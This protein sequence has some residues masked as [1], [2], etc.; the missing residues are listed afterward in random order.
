MRSIRSLL[1][2]PPEQ[3]HVP[4]RRAYVP[5]Q[6][7]Y[8]PP[9][10]DYAPVPPGLA[11]PTTEYA[12]TRPAPA[13][14]QPE[15]PQPQY[16]RPP[17]TQVPP[18]PTYVP[19]QPA[20][21]PPP[22]EQPAY[23]PP[24]PEHVAPQPAVE[25]AGRDA[26]PRRPR[27]QPSRPDETT[28]RG[29]WALA[30]LGVVALA[31][32]L[33][34]WGIKQGLPYAYNSDE[35]AHFVPRA[36]GLFGH[37]LNPQYFNNPPAYTY[38]LYIVYGIWY[39]GGK[40][41]SHTFA[42]NPTQVWV[43]AR[44]TAAVLGTISVW[45]LYLCGVR[46]FNRRTG[47]LA[48]GL[49]S[50]A[51][52]PVFYAHLALNDVP[53]LAPLTLSLWA[54][55]GILRYGRM[56]DYVIAGIGLGLAS[57]T[58]Y[59]G[60]IIILPLIAAAIYHYRS[61]GGGRSALTGL[62]TAGVLALIAFVF[63]DPYAL[64]DFSAFHSG[65]AHQSSA[66]DDATGK[67][68]LTHGSGITY[69]LWT[70]TWGLGWVPAL[71][72][73]GGAIAL[74][75]DERR[76]IGVL[77]PA[78]LVFLVFMGL[79][80]RYFGRWL[81]PVL[82]IFC[83]LSAYAV[84]RLADWIGSLTPELR[85]TMIAIAVVALCG[86]GVVH[87]VHSGLVDSRADTR[88][89]ARAYMVAHVPV[90]SHIV[91]EPVVPDQWASDI[92]HVYATVKNGAHWIKYPA[93]HTQ[94]LPNGTLS[95]GAGPVVNIEDYEKTLQPALIPLYES[96]GYC[97]VVT[98]ETQFGRAEVDPGQVPGAIAYYKALAEQ[99]TLVYSSTPYGPKGKPVRFNFDWTFDYYPLAYSNPGPVMNIYHLTGG[100]CAPT[101][102]PANPPT[103]LPLPS[104]GG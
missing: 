94:M 41:L 10:T 37:N 60:G 99:G 7:D 92:G 44:A 104:I 18:Q 24:Q 101:G 63:A 49:M 35:N 30:V 12:P 102:A 68:G 70:L 100:K 39:G 14:P 52:L 81:M 89:Q 93:T 33:R 88:N 91:V 43:L 80:D 84:L 47:L 23:V 28:H 16:L 67:L 31:L 79:Q 15:L 17:P 25:P 26:G 59:T 11:P 9:T 78:I 48:A 103:G 56:R 95:M 22:Q 27:A 73:L 72:A 40:A 19:P 58:K 62:A 21:V 5:P 32:G 36:I 96:H 61:S 38:L 8:A 97:Y 6:P 86:Q 42:S 64:L 76:L 82:P 75:W 51:F 29:R 2:D 87:S 54:T 90:G 3:A 13:P 83:L 50:V 1:F 77:V 74:W 20:Y 45:L 57:A 71:A 65:I 98:G 69:Y 34:I 53:T 55:A 46:L 66:S 85:P 4:A